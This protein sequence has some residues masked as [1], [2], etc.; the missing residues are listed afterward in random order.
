MLTRVK[1]GMVNFYSPTKSRSSMVKTELSQFVSRVFH[2]SPKA[3][4]NFLI[5]S[6]N[7]ELKEIVAIREL[8]EKR[9]KEL[10][11]KDHD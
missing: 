8:L 3:L 7:L 10:R 4:A 2:G 6:D 9:E 11:S 1:I 5:D